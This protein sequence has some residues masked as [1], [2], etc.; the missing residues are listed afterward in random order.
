MKLFSVTKVGVF[1]DTIK[2]HNETRKSG[3]TKVI[4]LTCHVDPFDHKLAL[5]MADVVRNTL[6]K[7]QHPD[8]Q[9]HIRRCDFALGVDRQQLEVFASSDTQ[10][11]SIALDQVKVSRIY[12]RASKDRNGYVCV[13]DATFGPVGKTELAYVEAWRGTQ[14]SVTFEAAE[15]NLDFEEE[16]RDDDEDDEAEDTG[17]RTLPAPEFETDGAGQPLEAAVAGTSGDTAGEAGPEPVRQRLT[18]HAGGKAK[19]GRASTTH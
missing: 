10:K 18:S 11:A 17:Q 8:P 19:G 6:F 7:L 12:V 14:R 5:A 13:F 2:H 1:L 15:P 9:P 3:D 4:T 16:R